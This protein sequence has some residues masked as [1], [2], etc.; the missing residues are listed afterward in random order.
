MNLMRLFERAPPPPAKFLEGRVGFAV[1][2]VHGRADLLS[3]MI[4]FLEGRLAEESREAGPPIVVFLGDYV[5]RGPQSAAVID[6]LLAGRP[7]GFERRFLKGNHEQAML[8]FMEAPLENRAWLMLGGAETLASYGV[9]P[10]SPIA[11]READWLGAAEALKAA[12]PA[13]HLAFLLGLERFVALGDYVFVHAGVAPGRA[14]ETQ[15]DADLFWIRDRFLKSRRRFPYRVV[16]GHTPS[17]TPQAD[18]RRVGIDTGAYATGILT[19]ARFEAG[20]LSFFAVS[21]RGVRQA[22]GGVGAGS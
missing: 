6:L 3:Q 10:P 14:L 4:A 9:T 15:T 20:E 22:K 1:G 8:A 18:G 2:D 7:E 13:G 17:D 19:A 5:D 16:H 21:D 11:A 12:M